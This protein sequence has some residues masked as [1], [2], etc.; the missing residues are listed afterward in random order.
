MYMIYEDIVFCK[1]RYLM[2]KFVLMYLFLNGFV[3]LEFWF[4]CL[5]WGMDMLILVS[6]M[7]VN[8]YVIYVCLCVEMVLMIGY[9]SIYGFN[10]IIMYLYKLGNWKYIY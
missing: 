10:I 3:K 5:K 2:D 8:C 7:C 9:Y 1:Y 6:Y 4:L